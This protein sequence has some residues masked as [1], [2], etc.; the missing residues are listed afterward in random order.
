[1]TETTLMSDAAVTS[2][3]DTSVPVVDAQTITTP[4]S[5]PVVSPV[6]DTT[7]QQPAADAQAPA[8]TKQGDDASVKPDGD[9][10]DTAPKGAPEKY[11]FSAPEGVKYDESVIGQLSEVA[12]ELNMPQDAAQKLLDKM[13]P[14]IAAQQLDAVSKASDA[15]T[16]SSKTD[17]EFGGEK[18]T[19]NLSIAKKAME[20][21]GSPELTA[22][23][24]GGLG[25]H[26]E[27]IRTFY[28]VGKAI[29]EDS[30]VPG[31]SRGPGASRDPANSLYPNQ[32]K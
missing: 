16:E 30:F 7:I 32:Q 9:K 17:K 1:M 21:F 25:N 19:E 23:L 22:L 2:Q 28:R 11:E 15:W 24:K 10:P 14:A 13:G 29:S 12:R 31:Q 5:A 8:D 6:A 4:A 27:I 18:L 3:G 26:P 20:Q